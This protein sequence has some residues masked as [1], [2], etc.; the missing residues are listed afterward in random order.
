MKSRFIEEGI[1]NIAYRG[2]LAEF[3]AAFCEAVETATGIARNTKTIEKGDKKVEVYDESEANYIR[4]VRAEKGWTETNGDLDDIGTKVAAAL[5]FDPS[6]PERKP[7]APKRLAAAFKEAAERIFNNGSHEKW[8]EKLS[9]TY[10]GDREKDTLAL[11][12]AIKAAED[13]KAAER[14]SK[15]V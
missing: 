15:Y 6:A 2:V 14:T 1:N 7:A 8:A 3:R 13:A 4:R 11:G 9:V 5:V 12:W 10:T